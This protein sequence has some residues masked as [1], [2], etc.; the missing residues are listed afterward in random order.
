MSYA[1]ELADPAREGL[2]RLDIWLAEDTLDELE[3]LT[4]NP[5]KRRTRIGPVVYD[6]VRVHGES[7]FYVFVT[8]FPDEIREVLRVESIGHFVRRGSSGV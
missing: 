2:G 6:F 8:L 5:P 4:A 3:L 7:T 1:L